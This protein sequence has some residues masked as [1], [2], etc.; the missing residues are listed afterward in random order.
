MRMIFA[1]LVALGLTAPAQA[2]MFTTVEQVKPILSMTQGNWIAV[3]EFNGKDVLYFTHLATYRCALSGI[4]YGI[5]SDLPILKFEA[6]P[7]YWQEP[8]PFVQKTENG[9]LPYVEFPL[10]SI[11]FV[12]VQI[13]Y[14]DGSVETVKFDRAGVAI[15]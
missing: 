5:N 6:E 11:R 7:C 3:R 10:N 14:T 12:T 13:T 4:S 8:T 15:N 2:Q 9:F 1:A